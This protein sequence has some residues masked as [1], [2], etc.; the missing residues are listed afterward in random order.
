[1]DDSDEEN[2]S[3]INLSPSDV[4]VGEGSQYIIWKG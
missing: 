4:D 2:S 1:M 3:P